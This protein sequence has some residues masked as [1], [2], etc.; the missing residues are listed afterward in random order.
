MEWFIALFKLIL[1]STF[2][3]SILAIAII[4]LKFILRKSLGVRWHYCIWMLLVIR[5]LVPYSPQ[6]QFSAFNLFNMIENRSLQVKI[7][8][9]YDISTSVAQTTSSA[10]QTSKNTYDN[11]SAVKESSKGNISNSL[12]VNTLSYIELAGIAWLL[13]VITF[14][15]YSIFVIVTFMAKLKS[16][17]VCKD[18][19]II[20]VLHQCKRKMNINKTITIISTD[21]VKSPAIFGFLK[22][23]LLLPLNIEKKLNLNE[24][25]YIILHE[26]AHLKRKDI[27][28][29]LLTTALKILHWF[30][31]IIWYSFYRMGEDRELACDALALTC[32]NADEC[33]HY[34]ETIIKLMQSYKKSVPI[35]GMANS[36]NNKSQIKRRITMISL[37]KKSSYKLTA[38]SVTAIL[39]VGTV[40]LT[41][42]KSNTVLADSGKNS[43]A[44]ILKNNSQNGIS[45]M[46]I[47]GENFSGYMIDIHNPTKVTV[48][49]SKLG[50]NPSKE[51]TSEIA[52]EYNAICAVNAGNHSFDSPYPNVTPDGII[53]HDGKVIY[54]NIKNKNDKIDIA[55]ITNDGKLIVGEY[56][57]AQ[58]NDQG[59][60]EALGNEDQMN[61]G[62]GNKMQTVGAIAGIKEI[63]VNGEALNI[64]TSG[65]DAFTA[66]GQKKD[67]S[68]VFLV[69]DGREAKSPGAT[70]QDVQKVLLQAGVVNAAKIGRGGF[71]TM[72]YKG[73]VV[74]NIPGNNAKERSV[75]ATF[76]VVQ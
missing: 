2:L 9:N 11:V 63:I 54:N 34:G 71:T 47:E 22:P 7:I 43:N 10:N 46:K 76:M 17:E 35:Y 19:K 72:Y 56:T 30:N 40:M 5:L 73:K 33:A 65:T 1:Y 58:L 38:L 53:V 41:N 50:V 48:G 27:Q 59:I 45:L 37:F 52:K 51:T 67:G 25:Q 60:K 4:M 69:I 23:K 55:G 70:L 3:G 21:M 6:S 8:S 42:A 75:P 26:M 64:N 28:V 44:K 31:P 20:H 24:I 29:S 62:V 18:H 13:G 36:I 14:S 74:N 12:G 66:I 61:I 49:T 32:I 68:I 57:L 15:T 39:L 16:Q